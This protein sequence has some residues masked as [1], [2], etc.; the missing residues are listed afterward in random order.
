MHTLISPRWTIVLG[1]AFNGLV[2]ARPSPI[3]IGLNSRAATPV[4]SALTNYYSGTDLQWYGTFQAGT[5]PQSFKVIFDTGSPWFIIPSTSCGSTCAGQAAFD[6]TK[7]ST[8]TDLKTPRTVRFGTGGGVQ[9]VNGDLAM[10]LNLVQDKLTFFGLDAGITQFYVI[11]NKTG[12][13]VTNPPWDGIVGMTNKWD[14]SVFQNL[15]NAGLPALFGLYLAPKAVD[16]GVGELTLGGTNSN[17]YSGDIK[18]FPLAFPEKHLW[19]LNSTGLSV[20]GQTSSILNTAQT[21]VFDSGTSNVVLPKN[22]TEAIYA[23]ISPEIQP[24]GT[25]GAY[26]IQC[27]KISS[28]VADIDISF[29][30][31]DGKS[32]A[33]RIPTSELNVGKFDPSD[34]SSSAMCQTLINANDQL[35]VGGASLLKHWYSVWDQA[36]ARMGFAPVK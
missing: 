26:G 13:I 18:Y 1:V 3:V 19:E 10:N 27:T 15:V 2:N 34:S 32:H 6:G 17:H 25:L 14:G 4:S 31:S 23:L 16:N 5:P 30:G 22:M 21:W 28:L 11:L 24:V 35:F 7:S 9:P 8:F 36:N 29:T 33:L 20:N 12:P